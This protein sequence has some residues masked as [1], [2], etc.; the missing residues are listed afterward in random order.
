MR[1]GGLHIVRATFRGFTA[2]P[3]PSSNK[4]TWREVMKFT[5]DVLRPNRDMV[6]QRYRELAKERHPDAGG[7]DEAMTELNHARAEALKEI[8]V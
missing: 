3:A 2:L 1:H 8:G 7:S 5:A 6:E 4:R